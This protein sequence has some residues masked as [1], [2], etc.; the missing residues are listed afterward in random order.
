MDFTLE[1]LVILSEVLFL[2][3]QLKVVRF[4]LAHL[5]ILP[6]FASRLVRLRVVL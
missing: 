1:I 6:H 5:V 4:G 3:S 2:E